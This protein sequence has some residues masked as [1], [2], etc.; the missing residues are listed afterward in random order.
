LH[1]QFFADFQAELV[2]VFLQ[3]AQSLDLLIAGPFQ[4]LHPLLRR[5]QFLAERKNPGN[6]AWPG[7]DQG[8]SGDQTAEVECQQQLP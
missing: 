3:F 6:A 5:L 7:Q 4:G 2:R 8:T 1:F